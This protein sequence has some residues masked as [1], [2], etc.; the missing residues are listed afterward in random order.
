VQR[1]H[2]SVGFSKPFLHQR[3][4]HLVVGEDRAVVAL[5]RLVELDAVVADGRRLEL[6]G[7]ALLH[8]AR[9]LAHLEQARCAA[10][11]MV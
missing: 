10:S 1:T 2:S 3:R 7:H 8:I 4:A 9:G 11:V 6:L 5:R